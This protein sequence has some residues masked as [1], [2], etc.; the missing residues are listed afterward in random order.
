MQP[1]NL[2]LTIFEII[3]LIISIIILSSMLY[4]MY[5]FE[6]N[7]NDGTKNCESLMGKGEVRGAKV[8]E[9]YDCA[10]DYQKAYNFYSNKG[11]LLACCI[12]LSSSPN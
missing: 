5:I 2:A 9:G 7:F 8:I 12:K 1:K 6:K 11:Q 4:K 10:Q 3:F